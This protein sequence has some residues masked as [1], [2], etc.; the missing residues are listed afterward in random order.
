M[1][2]ISWYDEIGAPNCSRCSAQSRASDRPRSAAPIV[3]AA[4][5]SRSSVN[6]ERVMS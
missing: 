4:I 1:P 6:H 3:R 5:I 2:W